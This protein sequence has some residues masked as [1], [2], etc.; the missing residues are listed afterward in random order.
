M[1][2]FSI[3]TI[4]DTLCMLSILALTVK[5][6]DPFDHV[7]LLFDYMDLVDHLNHEKYANLVEN[8]D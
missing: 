4:F 6:A 7:A 3:M 1:A 8:G 2:I 5:N